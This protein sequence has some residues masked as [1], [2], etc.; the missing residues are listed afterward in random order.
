MSSSENTTKPGRVYHTSTWLF[1][2]PNQ[3]ILYC[4]DS[5]LKRTPNLEAPCVYTLER[6]I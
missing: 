5:T 3:P 6:L 4:K 1:L 2:T